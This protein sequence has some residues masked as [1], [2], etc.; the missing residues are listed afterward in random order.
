MKCKL[1]E[2]YKAQG[3]WGIGIGCKTIQYEATH[4]KSSI[5]Q[6]SVEKNLYE[7]Q[8]LTKSIPEH[9]LGINEANKDKVITTMKLAY[10]IAKKNISIATYEDLCQL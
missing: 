7:T 3:P 4:S 9:I 2:K 8:R 1:C 5:H 6:T 10:F